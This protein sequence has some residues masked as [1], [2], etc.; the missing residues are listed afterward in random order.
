MD[1]SVKTCN[2]DFVAILSTCCRTSNFLLPSSAM[3]GAQNDLG[4]PDHSARH[5][6]SGEVSN[7]MIFRQVHQ[8]G[9]RANLSVSSCQK[10]TAKALHVLDKASFS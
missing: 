4:Y 9:R 6:V 5:R 10:A 8:Q 1:M 3:N 7:A 2:S